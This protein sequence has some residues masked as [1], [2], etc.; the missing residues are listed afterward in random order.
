MKVNYEF[1]TRK[2]F[3]DYF[4]VPIGE[5]AAKFQG[6]IAINEVTSFIF[7][8]LP[9]CKSA[10]E[11]ADKLLERYDTDA[12]TVTADTEEFLAMLREQGVID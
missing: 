3:D 12:E 10:K 8:C 5:A 4:L 11:I 1:V 6:I 2:I 9:V 7:E